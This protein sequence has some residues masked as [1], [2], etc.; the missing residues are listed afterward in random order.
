MQHGSGGLNRRQ[1]LTAGLS[2]CLVTLS[3]AAVM[4]GCSG[5]GAYSAGPAHEATALDN[6]SYGPLDDIHAKIAAAR[7]S[8]FPALV[9]VNVVSINHYGGK[10]TKQRSAG[11]GTLIS[12]EGYV[13]TNAHVTNEGATFFC[14]LA[15]K[16]RVPAKLVGE[17]AFTDLAVL[18]I[19]PADILP[20]G[21]A[22]RVATF[23]DSD[24]VAV[25]DYVMAM[26]SPFA[27]SRSV[28]LGVVSNTERVFTQGLGDGDIEQ[29]T[30]D[31]MQRTGQFTNWIQ[32]D[33][34][35]NPGNSGGPLVD[36]HGKVIGV[37]T[38]GGAGMSFASPSNL[39]QEV[40]QALIK[41]GE[42]ERSWIGISFRPIEE[43]GYTKGVLVD[44][45]DTDGPAAAAGMKPGDLVTSINAAP[46]NVRFAEQVPPL[47]KMVAELPIGSNVTFAYERAG[48]PAST[49]ITTKKLLKD[50][51]EEVALR[52]WGTTVQPITRLMARYLRIDSTAGAFV[53]SVRSASTAALAEPAVEQGDIIRSID[54]QP[55]TTVKDL[56]TYYEKIASMD[57]PP[58]YVV[59]ELDRQG[60]NY[61][62][63]VKS[64]E[65]KP[66]DPS[67][68]VPKGWV[69]LAT[70]PLLQKLATKLGDS[71]ETGFRIT[72]VYPKTTAAE[73]GFKVGDVVTAVN[74][75]PLKPRGLQD[76]GAFNRAI[77]AI[78][79]GDKAE[80]TVYRDGAPVAISVTAERERIGP[81]EAF[82]DNNKDFDLTVR[83]LTFFDRDDNRWDDSVSGVLVENVENAG[84]AGLGGVRPGD[85]IQRI[86]D[87]PITSLSDYRKAMEQI[88]K[89]RP[90]R[91]VFFVLR[92]V[93]TSFRFVEPEWGPGDDTPKNA[94]TKDQT[95]SK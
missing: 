75:H 7:D 16:R 74:G 26:G 65:D 89:A 30:I 93:S 81:G 62:T 22:V 58:E 40:A 38:R 68:E 73:A 67:R 77:K 72:R 14:T 21:D 45:V 3:L 94:S 78:E 11:S 17:D 10:E 15:D 63:M 29:L 49:T 55:V 47:L 90:K 24:K 52:A 56:V 57:K 86:D 18:K 54:G 92:G 71:A 44:S 23:G 61:L 95:T 85:L 43:T 37:N 6:D 59:L 4:N 41:K 12:P 19:D 79:P 25:G 39:A 46:V 35:I 27:L 48:Q 42:V 60:K 34:S 13:L 91:V 51:S 5:A 88:T 20:S 31:G 53:S 33:A 9:H 76:T 66:Q 8:V 70:Q 83:E 82:R 50:K 1:R 36:L 32:H 69:G 84:W 87:I 80:L 64:K 2:M 28:T